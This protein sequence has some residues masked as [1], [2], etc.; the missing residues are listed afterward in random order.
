MPVPEMPKPLVPNTLIYP[1]T[2]TETTYKNVILISN[3]VQE[4][5]QFI[6]SANSSTF[7]IVYSKIASKT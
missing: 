1:S 2:E 6:D 3:E 4:Y 7:P 5:Q